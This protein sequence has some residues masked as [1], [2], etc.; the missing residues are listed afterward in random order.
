MQNANWVWRL[1]PW[2]VVVMFGGIATP[3]G[4]AT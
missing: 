4:A 1:P 3:R 2:L